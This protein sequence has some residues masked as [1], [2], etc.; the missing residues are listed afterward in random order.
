FGK[1]GAKKVI[2]GCEGG[3]KLMLEF[4]DSKNIKFWYAPTGKFNRNN[5]SF[6]V[7]NEDFDPNFNINVEE[8]ASNYEIFTGDLRVMVQKKPFKIQIF[9]R[10]QRLVLGD[11]DAEAYVTEGTKTETRKVLRE[12]EQFFGLGE[13]T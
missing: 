7:I 5:E 1:K 6:A 10:Y 12:E 11:L 8:N 3:E 2:F 13:K 9:D 4:L